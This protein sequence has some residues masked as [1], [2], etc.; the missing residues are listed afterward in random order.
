MP[1]WEPDAS[2]RI[3]ASIFGVR[4]ERSPSQV[5]LIDGNILR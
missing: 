5:S 3:S 1:I 4:T 2:E